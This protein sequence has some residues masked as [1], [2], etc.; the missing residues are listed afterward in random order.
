MRQS[1]GIHKT[2]NAT[3]QQTTEH[4]QSLTTEEKKSEE[5]ADTVYWNTYLKRIHEQ[6]LNG[7]YEEL[8]KEN[9]FEKKIIEQWILYRGSHDIRPY[10][11][12]YPN[13]IDILEFEVNAYYI[14]D[15][16][17]KQ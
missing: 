8:N 3:Y 1:F 6:L 11:K 13:I 2:T 16:I 15:N 9:Y 17:D 4:K 10:T 5:D 12:S 7:N 14:P